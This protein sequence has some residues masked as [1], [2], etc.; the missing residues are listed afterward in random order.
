MSTKVFVYF[1]V[2]TSTF[3]FS[4]H[5]KT[6]RKYIA[7]SRHEL[8]RIAQKNISSTK[9]YITRNRFS[10]SFFYFST[11]LIKRLDIDATLDDSNTIYKKPPGMWVSLGT[12]WL[13]FV[14]RF[15]EPNKYN[16]FSYT[17]KIE[18]FNSVKIISDK[19]SLFAFIKKY[20]KKEDIR[21]YD[22]LD[23][24]KIMKDYGGL[25]ITPHLGNKI[26]R[27]NYET[28][29]LPGAEVAQDW[30]SDVVGSKW[31]NSDLLLTEWYRGWSC[32]GGTIWRP[33]AV[34]SINLV[35]TTD[36]PKYILR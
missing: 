18:L 24:D 7:M 3:V 10:T 26:W 35:K 13:D 28:F 25:I 2:E 32:A 1:N 30:I 27:D 11:K 19:E 21:I 14:E 20:K 23:W 9:N 12:S 31:K 22:V 16:L 33:D 17:Y 8:M 36:Y 34:A 5:E 29:N 15:P 4:E 6:K